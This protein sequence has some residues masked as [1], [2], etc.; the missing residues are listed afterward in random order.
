MLLYPFFSVKIDNSFA[1][2]SRYPITVLYKYAILFR[3][4]YNIAT[5][6]KIFRLYIYQENTFLKSGTSLVVFKYNRSIII[7]E[8]C[9]DKK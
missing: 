8:G 1:P 5:S 4:H 7:K 6:S 2:F 3:N 9:A